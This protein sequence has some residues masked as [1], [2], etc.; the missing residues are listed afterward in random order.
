M[1]DS[2]PF[3]IILDAIFAAV[4]GSSLLEHKPF[5]LEVVI[6]QKSVRKSVVYSYKEWQT[7]KIG[8]IRDAGYLIK[9]INRTAY[10]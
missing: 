1:D 9:E 8:N 3:S 7:I 4:D 5:T 6:E 10:I 2:V